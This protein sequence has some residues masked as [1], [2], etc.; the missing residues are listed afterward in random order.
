MR[1]WRARLIR[2]L[3]SHNRG[4]IAV[5]FAMALPILALVMAIVVQYALVVNAKLSIQRAAEVAAR[6][7]MTALPTDQA[8]DDVDGAA[9]VNQSAWMALVPLSPAS[10][11]GPSAEAT[12]ALQALQA[13]GIAVR[14]SYAN[15]YTYAQQA[16]TVTW[17]DQPYAKM[18]GG[19]MALKV[20]YR[21]YMTV[22]F[23][24]KLIGQTDTIAGVPGHF[25][26]ISATVKV[27]LAHGRQAAADGSGWP[28]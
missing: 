3:K 26:T 21:F 18:R 11:D 25:T 23:A 5:S 28:N 6:T 15:R 20:Q 22:P 19:E 24:N 16:T 12:A 4:T 14:D 7:A 27:Q 8:V 2:W 17:P 1:A 10:R 9:L 13:A